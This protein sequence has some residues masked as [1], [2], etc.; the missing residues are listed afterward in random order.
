MRQYSWSNNFRY[1]LWKGKMLNVEF[2]RWSRFVCFASTEVL[3]FF[4]RAF[5]KYFYTNQ[6][7]FSTSKLA[8]FIACNCK[9]WVEK[10]KLSR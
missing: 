8:Q 10:C 5:E 7:E 3:K 4:T 6:F 1:N 2:S 9:G